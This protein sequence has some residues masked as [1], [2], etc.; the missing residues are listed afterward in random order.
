MRKTF[1]LDDL[2][3][4]ATKRGSRTH[5]CWCVLSASL[6]Q[7]EQSL[8]LSGSQSWISSG[9]PWPRISTHRYYCGHA[10]SQICRALAGPACCFTTRCN[11]PQAGVFAAVTR[12]SC[13]SD[14]CVQCCS[15]RAELRHNICP[16]IDLNEKEGKQQQ[17][18]VMLSDCPRPEFPCAS[19]VSHFQVCQLAADRA[20]VS[21]QRK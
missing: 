16:E 7:Q 15:R 19:Y 18:L 4:C 1:Y 6:V 13:R 20:M 2:R 5:L 17:K 9:L 12:R 11:I 14:S 3:G 8:E 10:V 21:L